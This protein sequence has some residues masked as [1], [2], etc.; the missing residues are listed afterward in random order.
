MNK[1]QIDRV[2]Q[3]LQ[4][5]IYNKSSNYSEVNQPSYPDRNSTIIEWIKRHKT[6]FADKVIECIECSRSIN[7]MIERLPAVTK[8]SK[9][10]AKVN[11]EFHKKRSK[12]ENELSAKKDEIIDKL[13]LEGCDDVQKLIEEFKEITIY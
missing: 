9:D 7:G 5:E 11:D 4:R 10:F 3:I 1:T 12:I 8:A 2:E 6:E 13:Y